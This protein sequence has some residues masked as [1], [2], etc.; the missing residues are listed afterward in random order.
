MKKLISMTLAAVLSVGMLAGCGGNE[1]PNTPNTSN[2]AS[3]PTSQSN[4][5]PTLSGEVTTNGSTSMEK[6]ILTLGEQFTLD[7]GVKVNYDPT[8]SSAGVEAAKTG[9]ADLGLASR[10][11]KDEEKAGGLTETTL[12]LDGIA[13]IVNAGSAVENLTV[14]QIAQ[15]YTGEIKSWAEVGGADGAIACIG[16]EGGSGTRDGFES[17]TDTE[18]TCVLSQELTSTGAVI[19]AVK[20]NPQAIG[21]ASLS[22]VEGQEGI[23]AITVDGVACS[24]ETVLDGSYPIQRPFVLVTKSDAALSDAAQAFFD[25]AT[26]ADAADLIRM[27]GAVP[28]A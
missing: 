10:A 27:A 19:E 4:Q 25:W 6:V 17:I 13:I 5:E 9:T 15:I 14:E 22:S 11:L 20:N 7:T 24:E 26:S 23:K 18:G 16:R 3:N 12:A 21:Y 1:T 28:V 2:P 8:G